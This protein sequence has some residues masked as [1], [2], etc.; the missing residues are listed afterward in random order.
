M[1]NSQT[2]PLS[3]GLLSICNLQ[4]RN[5]LSTMKQLLGQHSTVGK[6]SFWAL[7][8]GWRLQSLSFQSVKLHHLF[9]LCVS[10]GYPG[11]ETCLPSAL[12][13]DL[14]PDICA[15]ITHWTCCVLWNLCLFFSL[16]F[17]L[18]GLYFPPFPFMYLPFVPYDPVQRPR[19][20]GSLPW[21]YPLFFPKSS[22]DLC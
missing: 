9:S 5:R 14:P 7:S 19:P 2:T 21:F 4:I 8:L 10:S 20:L 1:F 15:F 22:S 11:Q 17:S 18:S 6:Q 13:S 3:K 16:L 12:S